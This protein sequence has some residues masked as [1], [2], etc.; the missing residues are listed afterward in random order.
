MGRY[1]LAPRNVNIWPRL[2]SIQ[3]FKLYLAI[4]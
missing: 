3:A 4:H 1:D 2:L